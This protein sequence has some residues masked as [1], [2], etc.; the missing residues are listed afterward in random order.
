MN[1]ATAKPNEVKAYLSRVILRA[2]GGEVQAKSEIWSSAGSWRVVVNFRD[3]SSAVFDDFRTANVAKIVR[4]IKA[5][6]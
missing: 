1:F 2:L 4:A 3:D 5:M 6:K